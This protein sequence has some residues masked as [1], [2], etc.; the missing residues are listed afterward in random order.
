MNDLSKAA[1]AMGRKGGAARAEALS[2]ER[3]RQIARDAV[4]ARWD[5]LTPAQR[6]R[7][8]RPL[9]QARRNGGSE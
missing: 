8:M 5:A 7:Q 9:W 6:R 1:A 2:P 4:R 3:R